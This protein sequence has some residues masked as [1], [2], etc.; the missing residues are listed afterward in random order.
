VPQPGARCYPGHVI[1]VDA[2]DDGSLSSHAGGDPGSVS[3]VPLNWVRIEAL[4]LGFVEEDLGHDD[5]WRDELAVLVL[6]VRIAIFCVAL[7]E[8]RGI[9]E[10]SRV[11]EGMRLL[12]TR[13]DISNLDTCPGI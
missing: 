9:A 11:E 8:P 10:T 2:V 7:R 13:V 1:D 12:D 3:P 6:V 5:F 4:L